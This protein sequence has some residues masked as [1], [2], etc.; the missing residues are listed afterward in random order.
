MNDRDRAAETGQQAPDEPILFTRSPS[1]LI[2]P[3]D[4]VRIPRGSTKPDWEIELGIVI[5]RHTSYLE[6]VEQARATGN[7]RTM[8][9][10]PSFIVPYL[11]RFLVLEPD[12]LISTGTPP[13]VGIGFRPPVWLQAGDVVELGISRLGAHRQ[14]VVGPR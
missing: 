10:D 5:G 2:G 6:L 7:T 9:F 1:T 8:I 3:N 4:D 14:N 12:D 13:N 11:N